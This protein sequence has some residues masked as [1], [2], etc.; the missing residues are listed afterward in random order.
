MP[1]NEQLAARLRRYFRT[2]KGVE[3]KRM[4]G[5][6]AFMLNGHMCS[7]I[8]KNLLLVRVADD[9]YP[10]LLKKP[11]AAV[12]DITGNVMKGFLFVKPAGV[13][14]QAGLAGWLDEAVACAKSKPPKKRKAKG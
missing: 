8:H 9:R 12:M 4:F 13:K 14:T 2:H 6:V 5:G 1:Y 3:E 10:V 11:H 7:G